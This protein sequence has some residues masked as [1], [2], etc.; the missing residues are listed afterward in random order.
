MFKQPEPRNSVQSRNQ[1]L[2]KSFDGSNKPRLL[3][4]VR[5]AI[6]TKHYSYSTEKTYIDWIKRYIFFHNKKH[7][8][9]MGEREISDFLTFLAV[10]RKVSSS[11]QNQA[12]CALVFLYKH[13]LKIELA[14]FDL[15]RAKKPAK[16]PVVYTREEVRSILIQL[17][18]VNWIL[19]QLLYGAGLRLME[20]MRLRIKDVDFGYKQI[21]VREGKISHDYA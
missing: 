18:G 12:L 5:N 4:Q 21:T 20:C 7:P 1:A 11:T 3:D 15:T 10:K 9:E 2:H 17:D 19:G 14:E 16:L 8:K 13:V 6:R